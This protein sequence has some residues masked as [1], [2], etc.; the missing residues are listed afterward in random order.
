MTGCCPPLD[1]LYK[2]CYAANP[3]PSHPQDMKGH[4]NKAKLLPACDHICH[5][6]ES[7]RESG[8]VVGQ[9]AVGS[10]GP[11]AQEMLRS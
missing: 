8:L 2:L 4:N 7:R 11:R 10:K 5:M 9:A 6:H 3:E 1:T